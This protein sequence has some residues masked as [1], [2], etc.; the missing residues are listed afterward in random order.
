MQL[1]QHADDQEAE[2][3]VRII[4]G[5]YEHIEDGYNPPQPVISLVCRTPDDGRVTVT[6]DDFVPY[7]YVSAELGQATVSEINDD[8]RVR[9]VVP[10]DRTG[11]DPDGIN[12]YVDLLRVETIAPWHV[13]KLK[14]PLHQR[15]IR[16]WEAD[17]RFIQRFLTDMG[18]GAFATV[19]R[20][21]ED[22]DGTCSRDEIRGVDEDTDIEPRLFIY[23][24]EVDN[25][26]DGNVVTKTGTERAEQP[27]TA[28][29]GYDS[30]TDEYHAWVLRNEGWDSNWDILS[31]LETEVD[32][33]VEFYEDEGEMLS[34][35][36]ASIG[37]ADLL[38]GWNSNSFDTPYLV[39][40]AFNLGTW[41]V[42]NLGPDESVDGEGSWI[43]SDVTD[44]H[45][46]DLLKGF[47]KTSYHEL[48]S[49]SLGDVAAEILD[50][51]KLDVD[52]DDV[53]QNDPSRFI[54]YSIRDVVATKRINDERGIC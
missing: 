11:L 35:V 50:I 1:A 10:A 9:Q 41:S 22:L 25:S 54:E 30:Y 16:T 32:V 18:I 43:N 28:V 14:E 3:V 5:S 17:V 45:C 29:S 52:I 8:R 4:D 19:N 46:F 7:F 12:E 21:V 34:D 38:V 20:P 2:T 42:R 36:I 44:V 39:N 13:K 40:R 27:V 47:K 53:Y 26:H 33:S 15:G 37:E 23:D 49:F 24:I 51:D 48:K 6:I 31:E